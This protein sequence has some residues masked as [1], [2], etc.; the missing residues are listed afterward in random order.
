[1]FTSR[2]GTPVHIRSYPVHIPFNVPFNVP[3][4]S[5]R[6]PDRKML[7]SR[8]RDSRSFPVRVPFNVPFVFRRR[9]STA[10]AQEEH[11]WSYEIG[12]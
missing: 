1:M 8:K 5:R 7:T 9:S 2:N 10:G 11:G 12:D 3:S 4:M 6:S